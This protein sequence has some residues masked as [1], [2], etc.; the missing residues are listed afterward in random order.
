MRRLEC[1]NL[2]ASWI[3]EETIT[4]TSLSSN[5]RLWTS[6]QTRG[7]SFYGL[8]MG[9]CM[10]FAVGV[11]LAFPKR[12]VLALESDGSLLLDTS[13]LVT[14]ADV[15]PPN[16]VVIVFDNSAYTDMGPTTTSRKANIEQMARGAGIESTHTVT[17]VEEFTDTVQP[18]IA[19]NG[20][21]FVVAKV[22]TVH[23]RIDTHYVR[24]GG[25]AMKE[26]FVQAL[27]RFPEFRERMGEQ[28]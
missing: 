11:S 25:G 10:S 20:L 14:L 4:V 26:L 15:N 9:M 2:I 24:T 12:K 22:E 7:P 6:L 5:A 21:R 27:F 16:L 8:N 23:E 19:G 3:D 13:A 17:S 28:P 1:L 18:A